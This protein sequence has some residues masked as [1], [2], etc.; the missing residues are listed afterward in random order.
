MR[1]ETSQCFM[2][3]LETLRARDLAW[4]SDFVRE[5]T[6]LAL[7]PLLEH[8][9]ETD[10]AVAATQH[11]VHRLSKD[12]SD[13]YG[14]VE[15]A[16][17]CLT[18]LRQGMGVQSESRCVMEKDLETMARAVKHV[19][20]RLDEVLEAVPT[21]EQCIEGLCT[22]LSAATSRQDEVAK[23]AT[24]NAQTLKKLQAKIDRLT[25]DARTTQDKLNSNEASF[26]L[27]R[28]D[29]SEL[30]RCSQ[31]FALQQLEELSGYR[32]QWSDSKDAWLLHK[33]IA[34]PMENKKAMHRPARQ[35]P[36]SRSYS[37][38]ALGGRAEEGMATETTPRGG[39]P[40]NE[41]RPSS[42]LPPLSKA[43][44]ESPPAGALRQRLSD[45]MVKASPPGK[46]DLC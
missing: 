29:I 26:E 19:D 36:S 46:K 15:R 4:V 17:K 18:I 5:Q 6:V 12:V 41:S 32:P 42:L 23:D 28:R 25:V 2:A 38:A 11:A 22:D 40:S 16:T 9:Q 44:A 20:E 14:D 34:T 31:P 39:A 30:Q 24:E 3:P 1:R 13:M 43:P 21:M 37:C 8:L 27:F 33:N 45:L 10:D 35:S 7:Q